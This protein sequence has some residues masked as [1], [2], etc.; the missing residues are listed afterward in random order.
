MNSVRW[1][2]TVSQGTDRS[3]CAVV[4][5]ELVFGGVDLAVRLTGVEP[6]NSCM[7]R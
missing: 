2:M 3:L 5:D 4:R 7:S 6:N 1:N